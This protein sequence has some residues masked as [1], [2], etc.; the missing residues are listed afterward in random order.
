MTRIKKAS[1]THENYRTSGEADATRGEMRK[2]K[3]TF[4]HLGQ[5]F[6]SSCIYYIVCGLSLSFQNDLPFCHA[7]D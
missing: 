2:D 1:Y 6:H 5:D 4:H 7:L 3:R